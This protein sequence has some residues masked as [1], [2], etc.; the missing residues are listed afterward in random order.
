MA[1][2]MFRRFWAIDDKGEEARAGWFAAYAN[3]YGNPAEG[4]PYAFVIPLMGWALVI[5]DD[6]EELVGLV[7]SR[8]VEEAD[9]PTD[10]SEFITYFQRGSWTNEQINQMTDN[11]T[12]IGQKRQREIHEQY[13]QAIESQ[14]RDAE[15]AGQRRLLED[16]AQQ[17]YQRSLRALQSEVEEGRQSV[18]PDTELPDTEQVAEGV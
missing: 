5:R 11:L 15:S 8:K 9:R 12:A 6:R 17:V 3:P 7:A 14:R 13:Q 4:I 2:S 1:S 18:S 10:G 16:G